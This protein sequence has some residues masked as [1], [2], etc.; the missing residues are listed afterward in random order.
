MHNAAEHKDDIL[1][2]IFDLLHF[3]TSSHTTL[4]LYWW[5]EKISIGLCLLVSADADY[6]SEFF[7]KT[8]F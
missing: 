1:H 8:V 3:S 2:S 4:H 7:A 6:F 5:I